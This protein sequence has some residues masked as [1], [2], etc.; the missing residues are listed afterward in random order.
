MREEAT[1]AAL[2]ET[3]LRPLETALGDAS[4][5]L[6]SPDGVLAYLPFEALVRA[7][8]DGPGSRAIEHWRIAYVPSGTVY[9]ALRDDARKQPR[10]V[11]FL[12]LG[13]PL[14]AIAPAARPDPSSSPPLAMR[15]SDLLGLSSLPPLPESAEEIAAIA[16]LFPAEHRRTLLR[17]AMT[18]SALESAFAS[19]PRL[20]A[21]QFAGHGYLD[22]ERPY[23]SGLVL[24]NGEM[25]SLDQVYRL[26]VNADLAV[27]SACQTG[28]GKFLRGEGVMGLAQGFFYAGC[29][30][31]VVTD[32]RVSDASSRVLM[33]RFYEKMRRDGLAPAEALRAA[34]LDVLHA[35]GPSAHPFHW[36][37][38]VLW[39]LDD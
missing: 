7:A 31:V 16:A 24:S 23:L 36:A 26:H 30:R 5:L 10:G 25:L 21:F 37:G 11:D 20:A 14:P 8:K 12:G 19:G 17:E 39:G 6:V 22:T 33:T 38:Y 1:A 4:R 27:L 28:K 29:P 18:R 32:W 13:D 9:A 34:K 3:L 2:Y 15:E 35:G